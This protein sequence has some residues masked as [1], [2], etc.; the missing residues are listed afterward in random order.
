MGIGF[1]GVFATLS[2]L[3]IRSAHQA[4][5]KS[6]PAETA[7]ESKID[8]P[9]TNQ[10]LLERTQKSISIYQ[11]I[12]DARYKFIY[13]YP[14]LNQD[15]MPQG[16][17]KFHLEITPL[18]NAEGSFDQDPQSLLLKLYARIRMK[19]ADDAIDPDAASIIIDTIYKMD[20]VVKRQKPAMPDSQK[21][22]DRQ[23]FPSGFLQPQTMHRL[24]ALQMRR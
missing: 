6:L 14:A 3:N 7:G 9:L 18:A 1:V 11:Q 17:D 24:A 2:A 10:P 19:Q 23:I 20:E 22:P 5:S 4:D 12:G 21:L 16:K 8:D 15:G 13:I